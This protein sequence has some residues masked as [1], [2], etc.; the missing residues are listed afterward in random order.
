MLIWLLQSG[1]SG[2]LVSIVRF[3]VDYQCIDIRLGSWRERYLQVS[4]QI[5]H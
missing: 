5:L 2:L 1:N 3:S 4:V